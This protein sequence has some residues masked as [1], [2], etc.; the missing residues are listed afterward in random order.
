M[1]IFSTALK[2][3]LLRIMSS[4]NIPIS[5]LTTYKASRYIFSFV[6]ILLTAQ[7]VLRFVIDGKRFEFFQFC[8]RESCKTVN[9]VLI[10]TEIFEIDRKLTNLE[11]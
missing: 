9:C 7:R 4:K 5:H 11:P 3:Y 10:N 6:T 8:Q 1:G 2:N